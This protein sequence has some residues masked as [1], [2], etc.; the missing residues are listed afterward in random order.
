MAMTAGAARNRSVRTGR[1]EAQK[2]AEKIYDGRTRL[3]RRGR[4]VF[5]VLTNEIAGRR[6]RI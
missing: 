4:L 3:P 6:R 1:P 2:L 5:L